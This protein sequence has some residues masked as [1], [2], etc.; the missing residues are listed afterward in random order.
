M[1]HEFLGCHEDFGVS[2]GWHGQGRPSKDGWHGS[3]GI[4]KEGYR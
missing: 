2:D 4:A 1:K 3:V